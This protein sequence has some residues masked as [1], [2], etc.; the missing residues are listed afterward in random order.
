MKYRKLIYSIINSIA[1][2]L[3]YIWLYLL[4]FVRYHKVEA[5]GFDDDL[6]SSSVILASKLDNENKIKELSKELSSSE[7]NCCYYL[8]HGQSC[9]NSVEDC[10]KI[11]YVNV[12]ESKEQIISLND[13]KIGVICIDGIDKLS[14]SEMLKLYLNM[15]RNKADII[16]V[17]VANLDISSYQTNRLLSIGFDGV[18][19]L[20]NGKSKQFD[21][22][23]VAKKKTHLYGNLD[24]SFQIDNNLVHY[25]AYIEHKFKLLKNVWKV[26]SQNISY[27]T[28]ES[29]DDK[30]AKKYISDLFLGVNF[31]GEEITLD[32]LLKAINISLPERFNQL[33]NFTVS[34]I[35]ARIKEIGPGSVFFFRQPLKHNNDKFRF[36][37]LF[38]YRLS[39]LAYFKGA[40]FVVSYRKLPNFIPHI[41]VEDSIES[42][43]SAIDWGRK[44]KNSKVKMVCI[45][46]SIGKTSTKDM[47]FSVVSESFKSQKSERNANVQAKIGINL[48]KLSI[49]TEVFIQEV[50][51]GRPGGA[52][53]HARMVSPHIGVIT[54]IGTAHIGNFKSKEG[55][56][57]NKLALEEGLCD[58]GVLFLNGDD[59]LLITAVTN[60]KKIYFA[61]DNKDADY[62]AEDISYYDT[63]SE[64]TVVSKDERFPV[65]VNV[66]G[67]HNVLNAVCCFAIGKYL[68]MDSED[69]ARGISKFA[70]EGSRQNIISV[71]DLRVYADCFNASYE[72][73][74]SSLNTI[75]KLETNADVGRKIAVI[76]EL[77]GLG[78]EK[79]KIYVDLASQIDNSTADIVIYYTDNAD[80]SIPPFT[81]E[82]KVKVIRGEA[83]L[84]D[85]IENNVTQNDILLFKG[86][87][88][89]DLDVIIDTLFGT[90]LADERFLDQS[91]YVEFEKDL[92]A[93]NI[94]EKYATLKAYYGM[95]KAI[96]VSGLSFGRT[97]KKIVERAFYGNEYIESVSIPSEV[98]HIADSA[99]EDC[100]MLTCVSGAENIKH[101][102][103]RAFYKNSN[104]KTIDVGKKLMII[105]E[106]AFEDCSA[107]DE[108][109]IPS[110]VVHIGKNAFKNCVSL[111]NV[112]IEGNP[113]IEEGAF[114]GCENMNI[115]YR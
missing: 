50:G 29:C 113:I 32:L 103:G 69:I 39:F 74:I 60:H 84:I 86:S 27:T 6:K 20:S 92:F 89:L 53:K 41:V 22:G 95:E 40:L 33:G 105:E 17:Y 9:E 79:E 82:S 83:G 94:F 91:Q 112:F 61:L 52:S 107:L 114:E 75:E 48:Q 15:K 21:V 30:Q 102:G 25:S 63:Y 5:I 44:Q 108:I 96:T 110:T 14:N 59:E 35:C 56:M 55:L 64:F 16:Y 71:G 54:N 12:E 58:G 57:Y 4:S 1:D 34:N 11:R 43:I 51:G 80:A 45:T 65:V 7:K 2:Y 10:E 97:V 85:W 98:V 24:G 73:V 23:Y 31:K 67:Y 81:N 106:S 37:D 13:A 8:Y 38:Y 19:V 109:I 101:I 78:K 87:S 46:G 72:S 88:K 47:L 36:R 111:K 26:H 18:V 49:D 66:P 104:L 115:V 62:Y 77:T 42:H 28:V 100:S 93:Y 3:V 68:G 90:D 99:F 70:T 76:G